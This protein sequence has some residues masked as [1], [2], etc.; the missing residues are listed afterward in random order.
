MPW[1]YIPVQL[2]ISYRVHSLYNRN[3][4]SSYHYNRYTSHLDKSFLYT[5]S[6]CPP[7]NIHPTVFLRSGMSRWQLMSKWKPRLRGGTAPMF[8]SRLDTNSRNHIETCCIFDERNPLL[9]VE[10][11]A[12]GDPWLQ[13]PSFIRQGIVFFFCY[14]MMFC[15][16]VAGFSSCLDCFP[17]SIVH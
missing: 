2:W 15:R 14:R 6:Q 8:W 9:D 13:C 12:S 1:S 16:L 3:P 7:Q 17:A 10:M 11:K 5:L 4:Y